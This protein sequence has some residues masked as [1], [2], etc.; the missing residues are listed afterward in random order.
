MHS[1]NG[2]LVDLGEVGKLV[3][4]ADVFVIGFAHFAERLLVDTRY[5]EYET[6]L[7]QV[8]PPTSSP[9]KRLAQLGRRR[10]SLGRP[11]SFTF[12][13]WPH[14]PA[15]MVESGVWDMIQR[16]VVAD[17]DTALAVQCDLAIKRLEELDQAASIALLKGENCMTLWPADPEEQD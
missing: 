16:R 3:D 2:V 5:N 7:V 8:V 13:P 11:E 9:R 6:P 15:F 1:E 10:P 17:V 4:V 14:S 12:V